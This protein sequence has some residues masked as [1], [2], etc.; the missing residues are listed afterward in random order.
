[1]DSNYN[2]G[3]SQE[4]TWDYTYGENLD[5][6]REQGGSIKFDVYYIIKDDSASYQRKKLELMK[7]KSWIYAGSKDFDITSYT[8]DNIGE[9]EK[10]S[11]II[12][13]DEFHY[14]HRVE[15]AV[16]LT[17]VGGEGIDF[18]TFNQV[19]GEHTAGGSN[20]IGMA[21]N[22]FLLEPSDKNKIE[23]LLTE[24]EKEIKSFAH[25]NRNKDFILKNNLKQVPFSITRKKAK[26][27]GNNKPYSSST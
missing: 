3:H 4:I 13:Y 23:K 17:I 26:P 10:F 24:E 14:P 21:V 11:H 18:S 9:I 25:S 2:K 8:P 1:M 22:G 15:V 5:F 20:T 7:S 16:L 12:K 19:V 6:L 27:R